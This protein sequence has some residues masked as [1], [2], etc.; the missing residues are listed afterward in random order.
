MKLEKVNNIKVKPIPIKGKHKGIGD[1]FNYEFNN[2][3]LVAKKNSGKTSTIFEILKQYIEHYE[4]ISTKYDVYCPI[5]IIFCSTVHKDNNWQYMQQYFENKVPIICYTSIHEDNG[6]LETTIEEL[7]T[8]PEFEEEDF[9]ETDSEVPCDLGFS[10]RRHKKRRKIYTRY[11]MVFD[12]LSD[13]INSP[14]INAL[15]KKHRHLKINVILSS[16]YAN[17]IKP[18]ARQQVD[19]FLVFKDQP[20]KKLE[21]IYKS[22]G[23]AVGWD[24]FLELYFDATKEPFNF[25]YLDVPKGIFRKNFN[26]EYILKN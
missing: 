5:F 20:E 12:D 6:V 15:L 24:R 13:E 3:F 4:K 7:S 11:I 21:D 19:Q 16:Q 26:E 8:Q 25:L 10:K 1:L 17:D 2:T 14:I 23:V 9:V 22:S 18:E